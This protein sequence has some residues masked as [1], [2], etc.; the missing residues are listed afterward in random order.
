MSVR[1]FKVKV[2]REPV[3]RLSCT[4][5]DPVSFKPRKTERIIPLAGLRLMEPVRGKRGGFKYAELRDVSDDVVWVFGKSEQA[6][7]DRVRA[8]LENGE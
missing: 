2:V 4:D 3:L 7:Y 1:E 6:F 5:F 8:A